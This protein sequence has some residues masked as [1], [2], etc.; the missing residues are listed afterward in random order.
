MVGGRWDQRIVEVFSNLSDSMILSRG[1]GL[2][3]PAG[4]CPLSHLWMRAEHVLGGHTS[5][6]PAK[7]NPG[8]ETLH[9]TKSTFPWGDGGPVPAP[10]PS[11]VCVRG[12]GCPHLGVCVHT[13]VRVPTWGVCPHTGVG[14]PTRGGVPPPRVGPAPRKVLGA[15][16]RGGASRCRCRGGGGPGPRTAPRRCRGSGFPFAGSG[17]AGLRAGRC[18]GRPGRMRTP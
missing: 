1:S 10:H 3:P 5:P 14:V 16:P 6:P 7:G 13:W 2:T 17:G 11:V 15:N 12:G 18:R 8:K 4:S 9:L